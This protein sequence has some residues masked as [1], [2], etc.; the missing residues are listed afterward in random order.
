MIIDNIKNNEI[1]EF[2]SSFKKFTFILVLNH[3]VV[4]KLNLGQ[5]ISLKIV[6]TIYKLVKKI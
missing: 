2:N 4:I 1:F 5:L 6:T 3:K